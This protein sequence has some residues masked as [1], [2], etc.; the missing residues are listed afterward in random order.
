MPGIAEH[1]RRWGTTHVKR[2]KRRLN[3][4]KFAEKADFSAVFISR[5][6]RG[7]KSPLVDS[8]VKIARALGVLGAGS[9]SGSLGV[10]HI[11]KYVRFV[12]VHAN[13]LPHGEEEAQLVGSPIERYS[14]VRMWSRGHLLLKGQGRGGG[15]RTSKACWIHLPTGNFHGS[16][17]CTVATISSSVPSAS[18]VGRS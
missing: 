3:Q 10:Q 14:L 2:T 9:G 7:K 4:E 15:N 12:P 6:V 16:N 5:V 17:S 1:R 13:P 18:R 8:L 11:W